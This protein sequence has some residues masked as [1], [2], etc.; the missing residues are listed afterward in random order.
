ME[1]SKSKPNQIRCAIRG[2]WVAITPEESIRQRLLQLMIS[3]LGYPK[4]WLCVEQDLKTLPHL[5]SKKS[6]MPRRRADIICYA[7]SRGS[8]LPLL[9]V[10]CKAV[11]FTLKAQQQLIGYNHYV[12]APF[13]CL[14]NE[15]EI[16]TGWLTDGAEGYQFIAGL[17]PW[18]QLFPFLSH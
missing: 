14:A 5:R 1:L 13:I 12:R 18:G 10:E 3:E 6:V 2:Q 8:T 11:P 15:Q 9:L 7:T 17:P 16:F 4:G